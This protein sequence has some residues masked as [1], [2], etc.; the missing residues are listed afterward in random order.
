MTSISGLNALQKDHP[1]LKINW[2]DCIDSTQQSV[3]P[4][5]LLIAEQQL[6]GVGRRGNSWLTPNGKSICLSYRFNLA[7]DTSHMSGYA[8]MV[9]ITIIQVMAKFQAA[10]EPSIK[11]QV[12]WP[13]D[14]YFDHKKFAGILINLKP[15]GLKANT[16]NQLDTTVGIGINW[17][18]NQ[19][20]MQSVNQPVCNIPIKNKPPRHAFISHLIKQLNI[21]NQLFLQHGLS[22]FLDL[23]Q[24]HDYLTNKQV[25]VIQDQSVESGQ[26]VGIDAQGQLRVSIDGT[27]KHFSGGEVSV[28]MI[29]PAT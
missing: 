16:L 13:N 11:A 27:I 20:Q 3:K 25:Y 14:L 15:A 22:P 9:A 21:N 28:R 1:K 8:L 26:Y 12:K 19:T 6:A 7:T 29:N 17:C 2:L 23:W 10:A 18:L 4:N 5:S 24:Q